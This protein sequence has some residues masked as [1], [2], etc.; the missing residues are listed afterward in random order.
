VPREL[1]IAGYDEHVDALSTVL[2]GIGRVLGENGIRYRVIGGMAVFIHVD[3]RE[4]I[5]ARLTNDIDIEVRGGDLANVIKAVEPIG[6]SH[7][8]VAG[9]DMLVSGGN[10]RVRSAVHLV[11]T[12]DPVKDRFQTSEGVYIAPVVDIVT[13][14]LTSFRL[15]DKVHIQDLD[16][17]GLITPEIEAALPK[18]LQERL[19]EV[20]AT[21]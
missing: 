3:A 2:H 5:A 18:I 15:K 14:K 4:P 7:R 6:L 19:A 20:R 1:T 9:V 21:E 11:F 8:L 12:V 10:R 17:V 13:M 16:G